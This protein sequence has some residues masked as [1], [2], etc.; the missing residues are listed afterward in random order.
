M[1]TKE[2]KHKDLAGY[3]LITIARPTIRVNEKLSTLEE[4]KL[5]VESAIFIDKK[6]LDDEQYITRLGEK[7]I[8]ALVKGINTKFN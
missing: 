1:I 5:C 4:D 2:K 6:D 8:K 3:T 7:N